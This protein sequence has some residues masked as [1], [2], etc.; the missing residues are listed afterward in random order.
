MELI[1]NLGSRINSKGRKQSWA[2]FWCDGCKQEVKRLLGNGLKAK[3]CGC[4]KGLLIS[5]SKIGKNPT[6]ETKQKMREKGKVRKPPMLGKNHSEKSK[7]KIREALQ[8]ENNPFYG[9]KHTEETRQLM[10][11]NHV[12]FSGENNPNWQGGSSFE[13]YGIEFNKE[14]KQQV[15]ER[16]NY[17][18]QCPDCENISI[19]LDIHHIDYDKN[20]NIS[21]NLITLCAICHTKTNGKNKRQYWTEFYQNIIKNKA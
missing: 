15:L 11:K 6:E 19:K 10:K 7:E 18:C 2:I 16:D 1:K 9:K 4:L 14:K 8:G 3:S 21:E 5:K 13:P 20:N 12:N 17:T